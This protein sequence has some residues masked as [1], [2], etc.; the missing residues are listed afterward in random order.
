MAE[1]LKNPVAG[2]WVAGKG[3]GTTLLAEAAVIDA[4]AATPLVL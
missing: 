1:L 4:L 3:P 2:S